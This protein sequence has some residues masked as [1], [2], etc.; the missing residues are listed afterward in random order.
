MRTPRTRRG[1]QLNQAALTLQLL[2]NG[3]TGYLFV[4]LLA[5]LYGTTAQKDVFDITY[6]VPFLLVTVGGLSFLH[7]L[8][9]VRFAQMLQSGSSEISEAY[10]CLMSWTVLVSSALIV[11]TVFAT[12]PIMLLLAPGLPDEYLSLGARYLQLLLPLAVSYAVS[13]LASAVLVALELPISMEFSQIVSRLPVLLA[14]FG[15]D[16]R[17]SFETIS[18]LLLVG[19]FGA[20]GVQI[21]MIH[22]VAGLKFS[23]NLG[24]RFLQFGD[25]RTRGGWMLGAALSSQIAAAY[26]RRLATT[27]GVG[28]T[29]AIGY[30]LALVVPIGAIIGKPFALALGPG[31][32]RDLA[33]GQSS[34][35]GYR[36]KVA[37]FGALACGF[38]IAILI[39]V[40]GATLTA[41]AL[42]SGRFDAGSVEITRQLLTIVAWSLPPAIVLWVFLM[43]MLADASPRSAGLVYIA[44][45]SAQVVLC[46][47]LYNVLGRHGLAW[48][49]VAGV[50]LQA[51]VGAWVL[52][53]RLMPTR[54]VGVGTLETAECAGCR[55]GSLAQEIA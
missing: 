24:T 6:S 43:P 12:G 39:N 40:F 37:A 26:L 18:L 49:Y 2:L 15:L 16:A 10:S 8:V 31:I 19:S 53:H 32:V 28:T 30:A 52:R 50:S 35:A 27:D 46:W 55:D 14:G 11:A 13:A 9:T 22:Y 41:V 29:A 47:G 44:G 33:G 42:K 36:I 4:R 34:R 17:M 21:A 5:S 54:P 25:L 7:G 38:G 23:W 3:L 51:G 1:T 48:A 20:A 45:Y